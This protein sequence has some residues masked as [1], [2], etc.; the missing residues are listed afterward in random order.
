MNP[1]DEVN[2]ELE[3]FREKWRA[4]VRAKK[5]ALQVQQPDNGAAPSGSSASGPVRAATDRAV[6]PTS[7]RKPLAL[8]SDEGYVPSRVFDTAEASQMVAKPNDQA[9]SSTGQVDEPMTALEYYER[10]VEKEVQGS[11]G[12]SLTLYRK[13]FRVGHQRS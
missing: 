7:V 10:A 4:E 2:H 13:A 12:D 6:K 1:P 5:P 9:E 11:L 3:S 8:D